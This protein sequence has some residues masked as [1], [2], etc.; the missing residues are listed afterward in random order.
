MARSHDQNFKNLILDYPR[1]A[2][3]FFAPTEAPDVDDD[4]RFIPARQEQLK[5]RLGASFRALDTP[6]LVEWR[7]GRRDAIVFALEEES[8]S[9]HFS[10]R[11]LARY[12]L[13]IAD[14]YDTNRVVPVVVFLRKADRVP[15]SLVLGTERD[16]YLT[17][18]YIA[19]KLADEPVS[20]WWDS[21][22]V[23]ARV[24][25]PNMRVAEGRRVAT[26]G[27]A[28]RGLLDLEPAPVLRDKYLEFIDIYAGLTDNQ[29]WRYQEEYPEEDSTMSGFIERAR[30]RARDEGHKKGRTEGE[31]ALLERQ[32]R[33]R[34]G[35]VAPGVA[36][37]LGRASEDE[38]AAWAV[39]VIDADTLDDVFVGAPS[40][41]RGLVDS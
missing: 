11:H 26:Y 6:L 35:V 10:P 24:N 40:D 16:R 30:N 7:D 20:R 22:N 1:A 41:S 2:L 5:E 34:F 18:K 23:V 12:C 33:H 14:L 8:V 4:V 13:D 3:E 36:D 32:L 37:R 31:R 19:R 27:Q 9:R 25:L 17:F 29:F 15:S 28:V 39:N 38:L 21:A